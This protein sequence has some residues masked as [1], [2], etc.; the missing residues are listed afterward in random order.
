[1]SK[2][3]TPYVEYVTELYQR[4][5]GYLQSLTRYRKKIDG[6]TVK[7]LISSPEQFEE[8]IDTMLTVVFLE[9][10]LETTREIAIELL[11]IINK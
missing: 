7:D 9:T 3:N 8:H 5:D 2:H 6:V 11:K 1:M 4:V 10:K